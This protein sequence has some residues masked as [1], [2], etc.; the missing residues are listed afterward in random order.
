MLCDECYY[1]RAVAKCLVRKPSLF[2]TA[3]EN[4]SYRWNWVPVLVV[5]DDVGD[6]VVGTSD[7]GPSSEGEPAC[8]VPERKTTGINKVDL[9]DFS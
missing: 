3:R 9:H 7:Q 4:V 6:L 5:L 1:I 2:P 8:C